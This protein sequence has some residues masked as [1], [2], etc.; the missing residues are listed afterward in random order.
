[1]ATWILIY[2]IESTGAPLNKPIV[3]DTFITREH[4]EMALEYIDT[5]YKELNTKGTGYCWGEKSD[6]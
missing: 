3:M 5:Q 1:M 4:C 2:M 6:G